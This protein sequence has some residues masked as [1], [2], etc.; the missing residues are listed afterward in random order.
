ER[1]NT[2]ELYR[3]SHRLLGAPPRQTGLHSP[4]PQA[5]LSSTRPAPMGY[6]WIWGKYKV[7]V[8]L[9]DDHALVREGLKHALVDLDSDLE[10]IEAAT[11]AEVV[12]RLS[13][14]PT[15]KLALL[16]LVMPGST[17]FGL[18]A[19]VCN[20]YPN[21]PVTILSGSTDPAQMRKA[22]DVGASGFITKSASA[23]IMLSALRLVMAG[24][25]YVPPEMV[26]PD[27]AT[28]ETINDPYRRLP[29]GTDK[30]A[31]S[32]AL[33]TRQHEVLERLEEGKSNKQIARELELSE[34][35]VK[36]HVTRILRALGVSNR[37]QAA[38]VA[39]AQ[40]KKGASSG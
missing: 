27:S 31:R 25:I 12:D 21:L 5:I 16:D 9:A 18:L 22:L 4:V 40:G 23:E 17:G 1:V 38:V 14:H 10:F 13:S 19:H 29:L 26:R 11:A 28:A 20:T 32:D 24:G 7:L 37:T 33:T 6:I 15:I 2:K 39:R 35:T 3:A 34:H 30:D 36:I 8:L